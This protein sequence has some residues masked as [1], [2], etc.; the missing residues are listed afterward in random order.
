MQLAETY[1]RVPVKMSD[2]VVVAGSVDQS[3]RTCVVNSVDSF[4]NGKVVRLMTD[5][6][7]GVMAIPSD[8]S[9][10][11]VIY[12]DV[13]SPLMVGFSWIDGY[14]ILVGDQTVSFLDSS[15]GGIKF[16]G[17]TYGGIIKSI[18]PSDST[19]GLLKR[20]NNLENDINNLKSLLSATLAT[21]QNTNMPGLP[22]T[23]QAYLLA[24]FS[25]YFSTNLSITQRNDIENENITH[26]NKLT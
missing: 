20:L 12:S 23:F 11:T 19:A 14:V 22:D 7:D 1:N 25:T 6:S 8:D 9:T 5:V 4:L 16:N 15:N 3:T 13:V 18:D 26:D 21:P 2:C 10:I 24:Q 17:G